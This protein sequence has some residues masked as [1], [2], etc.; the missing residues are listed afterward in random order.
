MSKTTTIDLTIFDNTDILERFFNTI[1]EIDVY[2]KEISGLELDKNTTRNESRNYKG[3][4]I[5][6]SNKDNIGKIETFSMLR[7][8]IKK[9]KQGYGIST[10]DFGHIC[11][12]GWK[13]IVEKINVISNNQSHLVKFRKGE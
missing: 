6:F 5:Y 2:I 4:Y 12:L 3:N 1:E 11:P 8:T 9:Y 10:Y 13:D 7:T